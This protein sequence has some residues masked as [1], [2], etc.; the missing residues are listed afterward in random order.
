[1]ANHRVIH[2]I[3][4]KKASVTS[5]GC[6][7]YTSGISFFAIKSLRQA[8][9]RGAH[10]AACLDDTSHIED[11]FREPGCP[12]DARRLHSAAAGT[13]LKSLSV[14]GSDTLPGPCRKCRSAVI[15]FFKFSAPSR[16]Q[17]ANIQVQM[18]C[19]MHRWH[20]CLF[21]AVASSP[22]LAD[23]TLRCFRHVCQIFCRKAET[24]YRLFKSSC[25]PM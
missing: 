9:C 25:F 8:F 23:Q 13:S 4:L 2:A 15:T 18:P 11:S 22:P 5:I 19:E 6:E 24:P 1:M 12:A 17:T 10:R 20:V 16:L 3:L 14:H 7:E 21:P